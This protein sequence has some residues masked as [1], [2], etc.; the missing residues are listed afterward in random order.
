MSGTSLDGLDI[1][2]CEFRFENGHWEYSIPYAETIPY[3]EDWFIRLNGL[4]GSTA[5]DYAYSDHL[6]GHLLGSS[7]KEFIKKHNIKADFIASHGHTVFHQPGKG[8]T[9]QIGNGAAVKA[10]AGLPVIC[11]FRSG[12]VAQGGQGAPLVPAGD[13]LLFPEYDFCLNLGG[14]ANISV[15]L[16]GKTIA[17]D[18]CPANIV[19]N[20]LA[21]KAGLPFDK[22]GNLAEKGKVSFN[23]LEKLSSLPFYSQTG[24]KS[25]GKEW[26][27][28]NI[29]PL[30]ENSGLKNEDVLSTFITHIAQQIALHTGADIRKKLLST[31][32]GTHNKYLVSMIRSHIKPQLVIPDRMTIDYKEALIFAFLGVLRWRNE[33]NCLKTV[34][35][36]LQDGSYGAIY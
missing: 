22:E 16:P 13:R 21:V 29:R 20:S 6:F 34:T 18:I 28:E 25:L 2:Y 12:D 3:S 24:P 35:G 26:V 33:I 17:F 9:S 7:V 15:N 23:L 31:G 27:E 10:E 19:L 11:D 30:L 14:F 32:G 36:A 8:F 5:V 4:P 1:A